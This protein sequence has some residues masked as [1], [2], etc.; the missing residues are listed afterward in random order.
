MIVNKLFWQRYRPKNLDAMILLPRIRNEVT[1]AEGE[2]VINNNL[3]FYG[4]PGNGK[5]SLAELLIPKGALVINASYSSS[6]DDLR[7]EVTDYC[8]QVGNSVFDDDFDPKAK[9]FKFVYLNEFDG[10]SQKYQEALKAFIEEHADRVRFIATVNNMSKLSDEVKSRF[11][12]INFDPVNSEERDWLTAQYVERAQ[13]VCDKNKIEMPPEQLESIVR[14]SFPDLRTIM[15]QLQSVSQTAKIVE[16][17]KGLNIDF[18][19]LVFDR[20]TPDVTYAWVISNYGDKVEPLLKLCGRYL[21]EYIMQY[22]PE[23]MSAIPR[24][25]PVVATY[26]NQLSTCIDPVVLALAC[27]FE[28]QTI[29]NGK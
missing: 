15:N 29:I 4:G 28:V 26:S 11:T 23:K 1:N 17:V 22:K 7:E 20:Q 5:S 24:I 12:Q 27:I 2:V 25:M 8:R 18:F 14:L 13:L 21:A 16:S 3:L 19:N 10:V 9:Q 6:V